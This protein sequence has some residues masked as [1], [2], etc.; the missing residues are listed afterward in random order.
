M[1]KILITDDHPVVRE[2]LKLILKKSEEIGQ[3]DEA[4]NGLE[5]IDKISHIDYDILLLDISMPGRSGL[6]FLKDIKNIRP[7]IPILIL[8][9]HPEEQ[10]ALRALKLGAS[11]Y[12]S[13]E[14]AP[15]EL[16]NAI[17]KI[18]AGGR[19]I[20]TS[21]AEKL[22]FGEAPGYKKS[23]HHILSSRELEVVIFIA[24]GYK[25]KDIAKELSLSPKTISTYRERIISKMHF[26][27]TSDII[28][29]ALHKGLTS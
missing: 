24:K 28:R 14:S 8:S 27:S 7:G 6:D 3:I 21:L 16:L 13:K 4:S 17:L 5:M 23:G 19:Y 18:S 11:G 26:K 1:I 22:A 25:L 2:G 29:Y 10:Y 9:I 15:D 20:T 12:L